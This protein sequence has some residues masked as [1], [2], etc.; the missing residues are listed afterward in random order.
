L[1]ELEVLR[2]SKGGLIWGFENNFVLL[3]ICGTKI[4]D[5]FGF[6]LKNKI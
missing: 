3:D 2:N 4:P 1:A 5:V 6:K